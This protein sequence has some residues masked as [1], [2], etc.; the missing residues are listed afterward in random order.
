M[1]EDKYYI[2]IHKNL[3]EAWRARY[4]QE[5]KKKE[6]EVDKFLDSITSEGEE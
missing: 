2:Y 6:E 3:L 1:H 5:S 4:K